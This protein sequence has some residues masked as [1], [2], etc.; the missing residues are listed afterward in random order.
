MDGNANREAPGKSAKL[1]ARA[2][3]R[4]H[5]YAFVVKDQEINR[6]FFEDVLGI[7]LV[8]TWCEKGHHRVLGREVEFCHTFFALGD[9][10]AIA[11]F[12]YA[13]DGAYEQLKCQSPDRGQHISFKVDNAT[14]EELQTRI[15]AAGHELRVI[16][17]GYCTSLYVPSPDGLTVEFTIDPPNV[18]KIDAWQ[19]SVAHD[20][21]ARWMQ[22]DRRPNNNERPDH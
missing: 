6:Q 7:P 16:D 1:L 19:K 21:L 8:A 11:F 10:G 15:K 2:P 4:L 13:D 17:H 20:E 18:A 22:G 9:G 12:Q 14:F 5:H 3:E